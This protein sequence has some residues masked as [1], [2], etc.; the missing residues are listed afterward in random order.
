MSDAR[1]P[2]AEVDTATW[3]TSRQA[4]DAFNASENT[5]RA[6]A[7]RGQ[8]RSARALRHHK[9]RGMREV[10]VYEP[11]DVSKILSSR[12]L[13]T[14]NRSDGELAARAFELFDRGTPKRRI[15]IDLRETPAKIEELYEQWLLLGGSEVVI[16]AEAHAELT[17]A[18]GTFDG[19]ADLVARVRALLSSRPAVG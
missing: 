19:V 15:V 12:R 1:K 18:L 3:L 4:A 11:S 5:I 2:P 8:I 16:S 7:Q 17:S 6:W 10:D 14:V 13:S 9:K